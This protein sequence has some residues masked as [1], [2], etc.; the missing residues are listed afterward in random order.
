MNNDRTTLVYLNNLNIFMQ[1]L[2]IVTSNKVIQFYFISTKLKYFRLKMNDSFSTPLMSTS[3]NQ[4]ISSDKKLVQNAIKQINSNPIEIDKENIK[5][6][7]LG[8]KPIKAI[9]TNPIKQIIEK[10]GNII[11]YTHLSKIVEND[12]LIKVINIIESYNRF[13][14]LYS[15]I[16]S[17]E[18]DFDAFIKSLISSNVDEALYYYDVLKALVKIFM[19][20]DILS[21]CLIFNNKL[22]ADYIL[23]D[24]QCLNL[25]CYLLI[26]MINE[27]KHENNCKEKSYLFQTKNETDLENDLQSK[28]IKDLKIESKINLCDILINTILADGSTYRSN[29]ELLEDDITKLKERIIS[30]TSEISHFEVKKTDLSSQFLIDNNHSLKNDLKQLESRLVGKKRA[31]HNYS[32]INHIGKIKVDKIYHVYMW[33]FKSFSKSLI[34]EKR[35]ADP[36]TSDWYQVDQIDTMLS[37]LNHLKENQ[38]TFV[39]TIKALETAINQIKSNKD[40]L[41]NDFKF[42]IKYAS[43]EP[44]TETEQVECSIKSLVNIMNGEDAQSCLRIFVEQLLVSNFISN[45]LIFD[46]DQFISFKIN[47]FIVSN[48]WKFLD[49]D[50]KIGINVLVNI[51]HIL[52]IS[53]FY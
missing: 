34:I 20:E 1:L 37:I 35:R 4:M 38:P 18:I 19:Q 7:T 43:K 26:K 12:L 11:R 53:S 29:I 48:E 41:V 51:L 49:K 31:L 50:F 17:Q 44:I 9:K 6:S 21:E 2:A 52:L 47:S 23:N 15:L 39:E 40:T 14:G 42:E 3:I 22:K 45:E 8:T 36:Q 46:D 24:D 27:F 10:S 25:T 13:I 16:H 30:L 28:S 5:P 33:R 32:R